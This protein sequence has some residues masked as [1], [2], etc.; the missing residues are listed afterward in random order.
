MCRRPH[1]RENKTCRVL[2]RARGI[3]GR[4]KQNIGPTVRYLAEWLRWIVGWLWGLVV[5]IFGWVGK[6]IGAIVRYLA[7]GALLINVIF[8]ISLAV[9]SRLSEK[10]AEI[11]PTDYGFWVTTGFEGVSK[12]C[13]VAASDALD[14]KVQAKQSNQYDLGIYF[15]LSRVAVY[16]AQVGGLLLAL[17][18]VLWGIVALLRHD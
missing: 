18:V 15:Y 17:G 6:N 12:P 5:S 4:L 13:E 1:P 14:E 9:Q 3:G 8:P 11:V 16:A 2:E 7:A 10:S